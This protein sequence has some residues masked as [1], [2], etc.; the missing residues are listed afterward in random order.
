MKTIKVK[1]IGFWAGFEDNNNFIYNL[2]KKYYDVHLSDEPDYL[3]Y[4]AFL[5]EN[6]NFAEYDCV[7]IFY[8]GENASPDFNYCDYAIS[9][10]NITYNDRYMRLPLFLLYD[11]LPDAQNKH[12]GVTWE[13]LKEKTEFANFVVG[14]YLGMQE[15]TDIFNLLNSYKKVASVGTYL[16]NTG[17][18]ADTIEKKLEFRKKCRFSITFESV[19]QPGFVTEKIMHGFAAQTVPIYLGDCDISDIFDERAFI[20][21]HRYSCLEDI[22]KRVQEIEENPQLWL[23]MVSTPC[24]KDESY[25]QRKM[26][27]LDSFIRHIIDQP[28]EKAYRRP[29]KFHAERY[30]EDL[31]E[32][33]QLKRNI[34]FQRFLKAKDKKIT[35]IFLRIFGK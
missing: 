20:N 12:I 21:G 18:H 25:P 30:K 19:S 22:V 35:G 1:F 14:N 8:S 10:D 34:R 9:F 17:Y 33:V 26:E 27:E 3:F 32:Y 6:F 24:F 29:L 16:N 5:P 28:L 13:T 4:S 31:K 2:L 15:R 11:Q 7:R 23:E